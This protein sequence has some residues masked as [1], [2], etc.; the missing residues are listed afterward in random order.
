VLLNAGAKQPA[1]TALLA[2]LKSDAARAVI[3]SWGY[4]S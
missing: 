3:R 2:F 1:A 4:G